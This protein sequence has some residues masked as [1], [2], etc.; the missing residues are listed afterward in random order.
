MQIRKLYTAC[1]S[2]L[3][4]ALAL[5]WFLGNGNGLLPIARAGSFSIDARCDE[6]D[7][8]TLGNGVHQL[9]L[10]GEGE[11]ANAT[12]D[13][14]LTGALTIPGLDPART[15]IDAIRAYENAF[16]M[17]PLT[18]TVDGPGVVSA[19]VGASFVATVS[20]VTATRPITYL[21]QATDLP[22]VVHTDRDLSD[23]VNLTWTVAG[24]KAVTATASNVDGAAYDSHI[25]DVM[26]VPSL[27]IDKNGP[28]QAAPSSLITY[29]LTVVNEGGMAADNLVITDVMPSGASFVQAL[30]G[31]QL[32]ELG[33][34]DV[35]SWSV[36][37]LGGG[38]NTSVRFVV[39][40][41]QTI[42]N[43]D[44]AVSAS[45]GYGD[46]GDVPLVT[47]IGAPGLSLSKTGP[48]R[49]DVG[50]LV[51]YTLTVINNG[52][53]AAT[54]LVITDIVPDEAYFVAAL[55]GG[56]LVGGQVIRWTAPSLEGG[57]DMTVS[58]IVTATQTIINTVYEVRADGGLG[59]VGDEPIPTIIGVG[60]RYVAS[61]G[62]D[63]A[64][65][66][67][68]SWGPCATLQHA[69]SIANPSEE[70][71]V[72][73][74]SY[75]GTQMVIDGRTG[76]TYTQ[77][78][79]IT[80]NLTLRGGY[81]RDDWNTSDPAAHPTIIDAQ[82]QG[83]GV[84]VV[85]VLGDGL[86]VTIDGFTITGGDYTGL[87]NLSEVYDYG[88]GVYDNQ[89][90]LT[91]R[92]SVI[93]NNIAS[94]EQNGY[95]GGI[96]VQS[97]NVSPGVWIADTI[98]AG[99][100]APGS[101]GEGGGVYITEA[102]QPVEIA[103]SV[104]RH[105][106]A[107]YSA[108]G[109]RISMVGPVTVTGSDFLSNTAQAGNAGGAS[110][111]LSPSAD[112][113]MDSVRFRGNQAAEEAVLYLTGTGAGPRA[114]L[115]NVLFGGNRLTSA[116]DEDAVLYVNSTADNL[117]LS[118]GHVTAA[119][120]EAATFLYV[121]TTGAS[122][123][124]TATLTNTLLAS[125]DNGF[126]VAEGAG[127][128]VSIRHTNTLT[129]DVT[130][131]HRTV[132][133]TPDLNPINGLAGDPQLDG[134]YRLLWGSAAIDA[135]VDTGLT[136]DIDGDHRPQGPLPDVGADEFIQAAPSSVIIVGPTIGLVDESYAFTAIVSPIT[137]TRPITYRWSPE[138]VSGQGTEIASYTWGSSGE[139]RITVAAE[140]FFSVV[141]ASGT[142]DITI[143]ANYGVYLPLVLKD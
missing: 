126:A 35:V 79:V 10:S 115:T 136:R 51:T 68:V 6:A 66:C 15:F 16:L 106:T 109:M 59:M 85:G 8:I 100:S 114:R 120:N 131:L 103:G 31:G 82:R 38:A 48:P 113:S 83:R 12:G 5:V 137:T 21:W 32:V 72:A 88:G 40:A 11:D 61:D 46:A 135:G 101:S 127:S 96:Y 28:S 112:L 128:E 104:F 47:V 84:S 9:T 62:V 24:L 29:T 123:W 94:R 37:S 92:N 119:G 22:P 43:K 70:I 50:E 19:N 108:G 42:T 64:N 130:T 141:P 55:D 91:L 98:V 129:D 143:L 138:P 4:L 125:L 41:T 52:A 77:V 7:I 57:A 81:T 34:N 54:N 60:T 74:G 80:Q 90:A 69:V 139:K 76:Y 67:V 14:D 133:G 99:N 17:E 44:Y 140:N 116:N 87:R 63:T 124:T 56:Q 65:N 13:L 27:V 110:I 134:A 23:T 58:F 121:E 20:P 107:G 105:N 111:Y 71:R 73:A 30:D 33:A 89:G 26:P 142:H 2:A 39:T 117:D 75:T 36:P 132:A 3:G 45:G 122:H 78:V 102:S 118:L 95:G 97:P 1:L 53:V 25:V 18:V 86:A 49:A 93:T